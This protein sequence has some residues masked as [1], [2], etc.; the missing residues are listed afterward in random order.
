MNVSIIMI[1][2]NAYQLTMDAVA[3][4]GKHT[5]NLE[6]EIILI[7]NASPDGSG[8]KLKDDLD[9]QVIFIQSDINLG[10]SKAF[11]LG[12]K[13]AKGKYVLW[14]NNDILLKENF[15]FK[16]YE[17]M[18]EN[19]SCGICGGNVVDLNGNPS[20]SFRR[21]LPSLKTIKQDFSILRR[22]LISIFNKTLSTEYNF[23]GKP[24]EV[25]YI[26]GADM[27][28]RKSIFDEIG[29]FDEDIFMYAEESEFTFRMRKYTDYR[30]VSVPHASII[31]FEGA[32]FNSSNDNYNQRRFKTVVHG[33]YVYFKKCYGAPVAEKYLKILLK[34]Y[35]KLSIISAFLFLKNKHKKY[36]KQREDVL[37]FYKE[38][39]RK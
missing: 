13:S 28:V 36:S 17:Y 10:T 23:T 35:K 7:D 32:S 5:E 20:H 24:M 1:N 15:I 33:N 3:S 37:S 8:K 27:M 26:T 16:L 9:G 30:A 12:L 31:H 22:V 29:G 25:G 39:Q 6:Y 11:N 34:S 4:I 38:I 21:K 18:E 2:Y 14:L 19:S